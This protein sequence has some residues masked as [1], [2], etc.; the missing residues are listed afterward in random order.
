VKA[1]RFERFGELAELAY[2]DVARPVPRAGEVLV[3]VRAASVNPSDVKNVA[4]KMEGTTLPRIPGRDFAGVVVEGPRDALGAEVW[5]AGGDVGF[6]RDGTHAEFVALPADGVSRKPA[7]LG[8]DDA[9][10]AGVNFVTAWSGVHDALALEAG[11][12]ILVTGA[13]GGVGSSVV[14]LARWM[15]ARTIGVDRRAPDLTVPAELRPDVALL[16]TDDL[17]GAVARLTSRRGVDAVFDTVG[18]P[19][20]ETNLGLLGALGR[21]AIIASVG[22]R[23]ASFDILDFYH[24][25]LRLIG[26]DSRAFD[27]VAAA[28]ILDRLRP[29]FESG[30]LRA[31]HVAERFELARGVDAYRAVARGTPGKVLLTLTA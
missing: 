18:A 19:L 5:G 31:P 2:A 6:E 30:R 21:Y 10:A 27:S 20:F 24:K 25:R 3:A 16:V 14:Q 26:V 22:E 12:T 7:N 11:E 17:A 15:G 28:R 8:F 1:L 4:G 23:R 9:A 13:A 29:G